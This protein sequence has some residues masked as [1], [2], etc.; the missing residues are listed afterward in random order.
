MK[1]LQLLGNILKDEEYHVIAL[2][3]GLQVLNFLETKNPDLILLDIMMPDMSGIEVCK[4]IKNNP[5][6]CSI[7]IILLLLWIAGMI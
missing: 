1:N 2:Q 7:P 3:S 4:R 6:T 5:T